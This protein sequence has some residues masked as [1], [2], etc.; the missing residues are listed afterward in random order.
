MSFFSSFV[1]TTA[2]GCGCTLLRVIMSGNYGTNSS[3]SPV[4][5]KWK[6]KDWIAGGGGVGEELRW[7]GFGHA[8]VRQT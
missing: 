8:E 2:L 4:D 5:G 1:F 3:P 7:R 6:H